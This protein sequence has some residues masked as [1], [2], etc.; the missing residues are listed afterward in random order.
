MLGFV[1]FMLWIPA[2]AGMTKGAGMTTRGGNDNKGRGNCN[3]ERGNG[4]PPLFFCFVIPANRLCQKAET[5]FKVEGISTR[6]PKKNCHPRE[7]G[8]L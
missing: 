5:F 6:T 7:C 8:D 2:F 1:I 3:K 4:T